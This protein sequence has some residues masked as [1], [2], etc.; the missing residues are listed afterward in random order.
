MTLRSQ[1]NHTVYII[2]CKNLTHPLEI[3]Y[4]RFH[5]LV[6]R[7]ILYILQIG[8]ISRVRQFI[9]IYNTVF[10]VLVYHQSN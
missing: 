5:E 4:I 9:Q 10:R 8:K 3:T 1:M 6:I 7:H 2:F